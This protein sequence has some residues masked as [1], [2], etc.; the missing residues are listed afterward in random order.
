M[1]NIR[2]NYRCCL[3]LKQY[4]FSPRKTKTKVNISEK[5]NIYTFSQRLASCQFLSKLNAYKNNNI[6]FNVNSNFQYMEDFEQYTVQVE[7]K[8]KGNVQNFCEYM[9][10]YL[11][12][13]YIT[14]YKFIGPGSTSAQ[15]MK[16][17]QNALW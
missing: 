6:N 16:Q 15:E 17:S 13:T 5:K 7:A 4:I 14:N 1:V 8:Y 11:H 10:L 2:F 9:Y 12:S 3:W